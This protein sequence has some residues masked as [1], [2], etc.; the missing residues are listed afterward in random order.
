MSVSLQALIQILSLDSEVMAITK[1]LFLL[2]YY[3]V[4][5]VA[6]HMEALLKNSVTMIS[7]TSIQGVLIFNERNKEKQNQC[8]ETITHVSSISIIL[9]ATTYLP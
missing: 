4:R 1:N 3:K 9:I 2:F 8:H 6:N 7:V 5:T